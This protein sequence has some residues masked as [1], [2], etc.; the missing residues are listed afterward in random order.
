MARTPERSRRRA[1]PVQLPDLLIELAA[2][3]A[4]Q[5]CQFDASLLELATDHRMTGLLC[6]WGLEHLDDRELRTWLVMHDLGVRAHLQHIWTVLESVVAALHEAGIQVATIKGVTAEARWFARQGERPCSDIDLLLSPH[7]LGQA[8]QAVA[9]LQPDHPWIPQLDR[10]VAT[11]RVQAVTLR[12]DDVDVDL[13]LDLLKLGIPTRGSHD[14]W[15]RTVLYRLP[16]G[17]MVRVLDDTA[18]LFHLLVHLN[19]DRFQRLLGYADVQRVMAGGRVDWGLLVLDARREGIEV[20]VLRT[21]ETVVDELRIAWPADLT[22][23][24]GPRA[25]VWGLLWNR[26][27][28]LRGFEGRLRYRMRQNWIALLARRRSVEALWWWLREMWP[29]G[30]AVDLQYGEIRGPYLWKLFR[31]RVEAAR[32]LR[33]R[34]KGLS[35]GKDATSGPAI[36]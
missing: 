16:G 1:A 24:R 29:P 33:R 13:H 21:L 12:V 36:E 31:G 2:G 27:I 11:H 18:A 30:V 28:R 20:A 10:L 15:D 3:R 35:R 32:K 6:T 17:A 19:K 9:V 5:G 25:F 7:Q 23:P 14:L 4:P 22:R 34:L 26:G 8:A